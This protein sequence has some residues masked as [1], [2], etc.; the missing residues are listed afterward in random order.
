MPH[1]SNG[2]EAKVGDTVKFKTYD[3]KEVVGQLHSV[4]TGSQTCNGSVVSIVAQPTVRYDTITLGDTELV[5]RPG[6]DAVAGS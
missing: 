3:G 4:T 6:A 2:E 1:Y 5:Y